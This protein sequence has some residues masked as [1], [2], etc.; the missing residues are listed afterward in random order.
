MEQP[1]EEAAAAAAAAPAPEPSNA[2]ASAAADPCSSKTQETPPQIDGAQPEPSGAGPTAP[3]DVQQQQQ[4]LQI[5]APVVVPVVQEASAV[6]KL[7]GLPYSAS[8]RDIRDF[9]AGWNVS[10][11]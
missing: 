8:E 9:F 6:L 2:A 5:V 11:Q 7:K 4:Q 10:G 1:A 3:S